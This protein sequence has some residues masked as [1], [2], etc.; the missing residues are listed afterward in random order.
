MKASIA[1]MS[2][3]VADE[4]MSDEEMNDKNAPAKGTGVITSLMIDHGMITM[5]H[6]PIESLGWPEMTMDFTTMKGVSL[7]GFA[8]GD[9]V[10]FELMKMDEK[11]LI[12]AIKKS[13][14][15]QGE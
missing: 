5:Q 3:P 13:S 11:F 6:D 15:M 12:S 7:K 2:D 4:K 8:V 10:E 14:A 9:A 1:R